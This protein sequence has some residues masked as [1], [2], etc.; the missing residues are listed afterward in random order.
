MIIKAII[1]IGTFEPTFNPLFI[2]LALITT[3]T[4]PKS[5]DSDDIAGLD[6]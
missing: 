2:K 6:D 4:K 5:D 1:Y 3:A